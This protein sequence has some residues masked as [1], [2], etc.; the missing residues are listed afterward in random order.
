[1][2]KIDLCPGKIPI[3]NE[4]QPWYAPIGDYPSNYVL[5]ECCYK[6]YGKAL[7][8]ICY[9]VV[10]GEKYFCSCSLRTFDKSSLTY[11]NIRVSVIN[12]DNFFRYRMSRKKSEIIFHIPK[13]L[14]SVLHLLADE[15]FCGNIEKLEAGDLPEYDF[16][17]P[18]MSLP[19][20][21][22]NYEVCGKPYIK[23]IIKEQHVHA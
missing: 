18:T 4:E 13:A 7:D 5:C 11:N 22:K 23:R 8:S 15:A 2:S 10:Y 21:L 19:V 12:P 20:L 1:M 3:R 14:K 17:C 9:K 6:H 16:Q